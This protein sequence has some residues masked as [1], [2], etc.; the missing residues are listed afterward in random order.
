MPV[1]F[2][3]ASEEARTA[4]HIIGLSDYCN[5]VIDILDVPIS[6]PSDP[7]FPTVYAIHHARLQQVLPARL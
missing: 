6:L 1:R 7:L 3:F 5:R 4:R 2:T